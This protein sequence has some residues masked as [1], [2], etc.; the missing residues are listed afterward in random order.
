LA[1]GM[2]VANSPCSAASCASCT[3]CAANSAT[4]YDGQQFTAQ[5]VHDAQ[6]AA[7]HGEFATVMPTASILTML[8]E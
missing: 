2:T 5:Q 4:G 1:V 3:C 8:P 6:L 7:L